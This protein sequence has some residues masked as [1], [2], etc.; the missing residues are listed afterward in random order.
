MVSSISLYIIKSVRFI[1][2]G[3]QSY[4]DH[5]GDFLK[6]RLLH[7][8][9]DFWTPVISS[10]AENSAANLCYWRSQLYSPPREKYWASEVDCK[11]GHLLPN[12]ITHVIFGTHMV[13]R[14]SQ[15]PH[16]T[17]LLIVVFRISFL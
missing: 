11:Q 12:L 4:H 15:V 17:N 7:G 14:E 13:K 3:Q 8:T 16:F 1:L 9:L 10:N 2:P 5:K 6:M